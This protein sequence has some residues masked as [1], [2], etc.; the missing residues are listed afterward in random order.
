MKRAREIRKF[1]VADLQRHLR[2]VRKSVMHVQ[3]CYFAKLNLLLFCRSRCRHRRCCLNSSLLLSR[4]VAT[5]V[6]WRHTSLLYCKSSCYSCSIL[7]CDC[8]PITTLTQSPGIVCI[9]F[10]AIQYDT[11]C[12]KSF[13]F[14]NVPDLWLLSL[15]WTWQRSTRCIGHLLLAYLPMQNWIV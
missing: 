3:S 13:S 5:T 8:I 11:I 10:L 2:N 12:L 7:K 9:F 14:L 15:P 4:N 1:Q 6:T